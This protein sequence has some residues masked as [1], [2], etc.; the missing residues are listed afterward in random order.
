MQT[1]KCYLRLQNFVQHSSGDP[2]RIECIRVDGATDEGLSHDKVKFLWAARH[3]KLGKLV[4]LVS[5]RSSGSSYLNRVE[6]QNG[7]LALAHTNLFVP[8]TLSGSAFSPDTGEIDMER[9]RNNLELAAAVY[10]DR[11]DKCPCGETVIHLYKGACSASLQKEREHLLVF[12][13]GTKKKKEELQRKEP[14]LYE[15]FKMVWDTRQRH[16][17]P[18]LPSQYLYLLVCCFKRDCPHPLCQSGKDGIRMEW[19]PGGPLV[20][21]IPLPVPDPNYPWGNKAC[22]KCDGF[23]SGHFLN[24]EDALKSDLASMVQPPSTILKDFYQSSGQDPSKE[25]LEDMAKQT[26]LPITEVQCGWTT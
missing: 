21:Q 3:L 23:C 22:D 4:T 15:Y 26:L 6:L 2:K 25:V 16:E 5:S 10:I 18:G 11:V 7:C 9:V 17:V 19:F 1:W 12:L 24:P 13:K 14:E 20:N 8:S